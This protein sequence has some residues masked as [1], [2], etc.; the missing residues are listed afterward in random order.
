MGRREMEEM[1]MEIEEWSSLLAIDTFF[2]QS[3]WQSTMDD[4]SL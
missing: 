2:V 4:E 1:Y 3:T